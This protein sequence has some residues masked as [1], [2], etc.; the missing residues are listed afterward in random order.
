MKNEN[1]KS[2][3]FNCIFGNGTVIFSSR[4]CVTHTHSLTL[5]HTNKKSV[6][7]CVRLLHKISIR[8]PWSAIMIE[9]I[10]NNRIYEL[11][12]RLRSFCIIADC[13][14]W[15][16]P[17]TLALGSTHLISSHNLSLSLSYALKRS[18]ILI[19][20]RR[21]SLTAPEWIKKTPFQR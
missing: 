16:L 4:K 11:Y 2:R 19:W 20:R 5:S 3:V 8:W 1:F 7:R 14:L 9:Y 17:F 6:A 12:R 21:L 18:T 13:T 10:A 15:I